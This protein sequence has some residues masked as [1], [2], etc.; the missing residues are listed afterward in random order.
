MRRTSSAASSPASWPSRSLSAP[1]TIPGGAALA[2]MVCQRGDLALQRGAG[3][4]D[5][6]KSM[7]GVE[8]GFS[9]E[10]YLCRDGHRIVE[11]QRPH[12]G[13]NPRV[14]PDRWPVQLQD[15]IREA[16][17]GVGDL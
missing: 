16:I 6:G 7:R 14:L 2:L 5:P 4:G 10:L 11:G 17:D 13:S 15:Q 8:K 1:C 3:D 12:T 9:L